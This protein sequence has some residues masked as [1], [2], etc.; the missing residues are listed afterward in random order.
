MEDAKGTTPEAAGAQQ[1]AERHDT[2]LFMEPGR[3][4]ST[5]YVRVR[6]ANGQ[7]M[8]TDPDSPA[9]LRRAKRKAQAAKRHIN[10]ER[11]YLKTLA[12]ALDHEDV[13]NVVLAVV[14]DAIDG[15]EKCRNAAREWLGK[16]ALGNGKESL[17]LVLHPEVI[18]GKR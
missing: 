7:F 16:Y 1:T 14:R 3:R 18:R 11:E 8:P 12:R 2:V 17:D 9:A 5:T 13:H 4:G 15:E 10:T 6:G